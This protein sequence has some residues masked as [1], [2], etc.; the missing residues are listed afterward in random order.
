MPS[1][2]DRLVAEL[3]LDDFSKALTPAQRDGFIRAVSETAF[4][5]RPHERR[6]IE[7][8][9][10]KAKALPLLGDEADD[11]DIRTAARE[12]QQRSAVEASTLDGKPR[13]KKV[14]PEPMSKARHAAPISGA[15]LVADA[16]RIADQVQQNHAAIRDQHRQ[17]VRQQARER[18]RETLAKA[19]AAFHAGR[20]TGHQVAVI[21]AL[22]H[23]NMAAA[24]KLEAGR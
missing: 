5:S 22:A 15:Q 7:E 17:V 14:A 19:L 18:T 21:E 6:V 20:L 23:R 11:K 8:A 1:E 13:K 2:F 9:F 4:G 12:G 24:A 10:Q 3:Q 16:K